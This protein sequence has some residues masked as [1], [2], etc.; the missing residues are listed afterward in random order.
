MPLL[1]LVALALALPVG[2]L[3]AGTAPSF[4][5]DCGCT[6][7]QEYKSMHAAIKLGRHAQRYTAASFHDMGEAQTHKKGAICETAQ[8]L[9]AC[10]KLRRVCAQASAT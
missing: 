8:F 9:R 4:P 1:R 2:M 6:W 5:E 3:A 7:Q 10:D